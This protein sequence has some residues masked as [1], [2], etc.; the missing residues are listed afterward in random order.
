MSWPESVDEALCFGWID[1]VRKRIDEQSYLIRFT[2]RRATSIWSLVN[3]AKFK[4]LQ[5]QGR[6]HPRGVAAYE[7]R[8]SK[9][10]GIYAFEQEVTAELTVAETKVFKA[11]K[12]GWSYF[13]SAA[14]SYRKVML[15]WVVS[16]KQPATRERRFSQLVQA[17]AEQKRILR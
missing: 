11:N 7:A 17:C 6:M 8:S 10:T 13:E 12:V 4:N 9:K 1:G 5:A 14:P 15:H 2:P 3:V 16:A